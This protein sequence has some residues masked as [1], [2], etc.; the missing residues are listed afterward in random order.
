VPCEESR[1]RGGDPVFVPPVQS[2]D[3]LLPRAPRRALAGAHE[4]LQGAAAEM[5]PPGVQEASGNQV[6]QVHG[7]DVLQ[8][9]ARGGSLA[10][11]REQ[12]QG[13]A[14]VQIDIVARKRMVDGGKMQVQGAARV[15]IDR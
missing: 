5:R 13:A 2:G 11:A 4:L 1:G 9:G 15:Q 7:G 14:Q 6:R 8:Q 3:V 12:V 10:G